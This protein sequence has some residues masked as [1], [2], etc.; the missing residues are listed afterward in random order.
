LKLIS[1]LKHNNI[2]NFIGFVVEEN[3]FGIVL[4]FC[5]NGSLKK[6]LENF[7]KNLSFS[8]KLKILIDIS[9]GMEYLHFKKIIHRFEILKL[10]Y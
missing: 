2:V 5:K 6:Y 7:S 9:K 3:K 4:E 1:K 10:N 8:S